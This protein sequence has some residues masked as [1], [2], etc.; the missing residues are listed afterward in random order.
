MD[1]IFSI[2]IGFFGA[3]CLWWKNKRQFERTNEFGEERF[4]SYWKKV[5]EKFFD[6]FLRYSGLALFSTGVILIAL[7]YAEEWVYL[8]AFFLIAFSIENIYYRDRRKMG[9]V[10]IISR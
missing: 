7:K 3:T 6:E 2:F 5:K 4:S 1:D 10:K 8:F 9:H